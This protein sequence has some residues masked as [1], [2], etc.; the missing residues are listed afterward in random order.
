MTGSAPSAPSRRTRPVL[1]ALAVGAGLAAGAWWTGVFRSLEPEDTVQ[2]G[3]VALASWEDNRLSGLALGVPAGPQALGERR[4]TFHPDEPLMLE[5]S[6]RPAEREPGVSYEW[7]GPDGDLAF[8][9]RLTVASGWSNTWSTYRGPTPML[10]G[11]WT[12]VVTDGRRRAGAIGFEVVREPSD[13]VLSVAAS[14]SATG[15]LDPEEAAA[16]ARALRDVLAGEGSAETLV[17]SLSEP[18]GALGLQLALAVHGSG[19]SEA[20]LGAGDTLAASVRSALD[21]WPAYDPATDTLTLSLLHSAEAL[22]P[23]PRHVTARLGRE[24]GFS[25][26]LGDRAATLTPWAVTARND[27]NGEA[28]LRQL[29]VDLGAEE[30]AWQQEG[31]ILSAF[32]AQDFVVLPGATAATPVA[33]GRSVVDPA[34]LSHTRLTEAVDLAAG[35]FLANQHA[36]GRYLYSALPGPGVE[37]IEDWC[38]RVLNAVFVMAEIA[39]ARPAQPALKASVL[40]ALVP[41]IEQLE[42]RG[43][44]AFLDWPQLPK[45]SGL[46]STAFLLAALATLDRPVTEDLRQQLASAILAE[47]G[48]DGRFSTDFVGA[49]K[50]VDQQYYPGEAML[51]L[52]RH[53]RVSGDPRVPEALALA[54]EHYSDRWLTQRDAPY[55]P[56]QSRAFAELHRVQPDPRYAAYV[57]DLTDWLLDTR[58]TQPSTEGPVFAGALGTEFAASGVYAEGLAAAWDL[59]RRVG[60]TARERRYGDALVQATRYNLGLQLQPGD[61]HGFPRPELALGALVTQPG[62]NALRLDFTYHAISAAHA[63]T[64]LTTG[65]EWE[66]LRARVYGAP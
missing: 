40:G 4:A 32:Q 5:S 48:P 22:D 55:V 9:S 17:A 34:D 21:P 46:G 30:T 58:P 12:L 27:T 15:P 11:A 31:A 23:S 14:P 61:V 54:F 50:P 3:E 24:A 26:L 28:V 10:A 35:W 49:D 53:H 45:D 64:Q 43:G 39:V 51:A 65:E 20:R 38:L 44:T 18:S 36:D 6:W 59:A 41:F 8:L 7:Y 16:F 47:Q 62:D 42:H 1:A 25:L 63:V 19:G 60:D 37:P 57:F 52:V 56:W 2:P 29:A 13:P 33:D 66:G